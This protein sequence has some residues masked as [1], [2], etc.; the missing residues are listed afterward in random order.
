MAGLDFFRVR[1]PDS[2]TLEQ[3]YSNPKLVTE[4]CIKA[5]GLHRTV[6]NEQIPIESLGE[7]VQSKNIQTA[8]EEHGL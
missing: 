1:A 7:P 4:Y 2:V 8:G 5:S 6:V 3:L